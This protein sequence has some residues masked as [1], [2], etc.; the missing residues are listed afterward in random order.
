MQKIIHMAKRFIEN[1]GTAILFGMLICVMI[2]MV[3]LTRSQAET[4][5]YLTPDQFGAKHGAI[6]FRELGKNQTWCNTNYPGMSVTPDTRVDAAAWT[7]ALHKAGETGKMIIAFGYYDFG[8]DSAIFPKNFRC[9]TITGGA[10]IRVTGTNGSP[11]FTRPRPTDNGD[12]NIMIGSFVNINGLQIGC[13]TGSQANR[14]GIEIGPTYNSMYTRV[15][16]FSLSEAIHLRFALNTKLT[17]CE[18]QYCNR[19]WTAD[20]GN[21]PG[22]G[23]ANSQSNETTFEHCRFNADNSDYGIGIYAASGCV[24]QSC[25][26]EGVQVR[27]GIDYDSKGSTVVK[28]MKIDNS[29]FECVNGAAEAF[30]KARLSG[31]VLTVSRCF[32]QY[33]AVMVDASTSGAAYPFVE[34][35]HTLYWVPS[36]TG[37]YFK[38]NGCNWA[39]NY[40]DNFSSNWADFRNMFSGTQPNYCT[41]TSGACGSNTYSALMTGR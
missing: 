23:N 5:P 8:N 4:L 3:S 2:L 32:G 12:A 20:M 14:I 6:T 25:I 21:W 33:A 22:A 28:G 36:P 40:N 34:V 27:V 24:V 31:G 29:H 39:L 35:S 9:I 17:M 37:K 16:C 13:Q 1:W 30:I 15:D 41:V 26:I 10:Y 18:A 19:G 11:V 7:K 38:N